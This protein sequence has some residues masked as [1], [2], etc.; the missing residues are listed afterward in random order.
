MHSVCLV[1][2]LT[3]NVYEQWHV[4]NITRLTLIIVFASVVCNF[5]EIDGNMRRLQYTQG[6]VEGMADSQKK[7]HNQMKKL[8]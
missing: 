1:E 7:L 8:S 3:D 5:H 6:H 4:D 2:I